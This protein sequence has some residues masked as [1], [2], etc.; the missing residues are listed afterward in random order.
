[1]EWVRNW[2]SNMIPADKP[3]VDE[4]GVVYLATENYYQA[5]KMPDVERRRKLADMS[6][7]A[8]K[9]AVRTPA[10]KLTP[11]QWAAFE[12]KKLLVM[13]TALRQKFSPGTTWYEKLMATGEEEIVEWNNWNDKYWGRTLDGVGENNLG[14]LL[15]KLRNEYRNKGENA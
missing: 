8:S 9:R 7:T 6:P 2:F 11:E 14:K 4:L 5:A 3:L 1:M 12:S 10:F 15:M 13:E